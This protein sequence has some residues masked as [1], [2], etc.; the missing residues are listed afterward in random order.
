MRG[1]FGALVLGLA[2][3]PASHAAQDRFCIAFS[4]AG[5]IT[6]ITEPFTSRASQADAEAYF[7]NQLDSAQVRYDAVQCPAPESNAGTQASLATARSFNAK[8]GF[9]VLTLR[10]SG[11]QL[12][13]SRR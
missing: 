1:L 2:M 9:K 8:M 7:R 4:F 10:F 6:Y 11:N 5:R 13:L 3:T 12:V